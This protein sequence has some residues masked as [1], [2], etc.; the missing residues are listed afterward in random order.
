MEQPQTPRPNKPKANLYII[1]IFILLIAVI[2]QQNR[3]ANNLQERVNGLHNTVVNDSF[4][5]TH[6]L[7]HLSNMINQ[8]Q[9]QLY[10]STRASFNE[11][12]QILSHSQNGAETAISFYLREHNAGDNIIV[13]ARGQRDGEA[14]SAVAAF[15]NG[16]FQAN[17]T[18]P[19]RDNYTITF[20][21]EGTA[22]GATIQTGELLQFNLANTLTQRLSFWPGDSPRW[23]GRAQFPTVINFNPQFRNFTNGN[24][25]LNVSHLSLYI[26]TADAVPR[27]ITSWNLTPYL[28][29]THDGQTLHLGETILSVR[30]SDVD[31]GAVAFTQTIAVARLVIYDELGLR[32]EQQ[33]SIINWHR[34]FADGRPTEVAMPMP[35]RSIYINIDGSNPWE[36]RIM[37]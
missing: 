36:M 32:Y 19:L 2:I 27:A 22:P 34:G 6:N 24:Q 26:E 20:A 35:D 8:L 4:N 30:V 11:T 33:H 31:Y 37:E 18:L 25:I 23:D 17:L 16:R 1:V 3:L 10:Q 5:T 9:N 15:S 21:T 29:N 14:H 7:H 13:T 28:R 12:V